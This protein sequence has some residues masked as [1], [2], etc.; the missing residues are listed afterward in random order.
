MIEQRG[1]RIGGG[2]REPVSATI[3][4]L[5]I[6]AVIFFS[7]HLSE[8]YIGRLFIYLSTIMALKHTQNQAQVILHLLEV[9]ADKLMQT[10]QKA[11]AKQL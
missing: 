9:G 3:S 6:H 10:Y 11:F 1:F 5:T 8:A 2:K 7:L 4:R